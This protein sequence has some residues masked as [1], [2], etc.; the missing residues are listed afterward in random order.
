MHR[1]CL[2]RHDHALRP[3]AEESCRPMAC[4]LLGTYI[5]RR[6]HF[7]LTISTYFSIIMAPPE[8]PQASQIRKEV[9][10]YYFSALG[11][12]SFHD[13]DDTGSLQENL[14]NIQRH[15]AR[16]FVLDFSDV[17]AWI[18]CDL[19][20]TAI[21]A[22]LEAERPESLSTRWIN[23]WSPQRQASL[24]EVIAKKYDFS[25]RL[26]ALM[27]S[28]P[29]RRNSGR[30]GRS[31]SSRSYSNKFLR[32]PRASPAPQTVSED[33]IEKG[34]DDL[35]ELSAV[36][37]L[38]S[39]SRGNL[40]RIIDD[41]WHY[42][43]IDFGRSFVCMGYNSLYG[44]EDPT[45]ENAGG[46]LPRCVRLWTWLV[47][48]DDHT[49]ISI[50]EDPF[51]Y[52][53]GRLAESQ[54]RVLTETRRNL[55]NVFRSLS[56]AEQA[57]LLQHKPLALF[58]IRARLG[59][60][61]EESAHRLA[62]TPG[63]LFYFL[64]ENWHNSYTLITRRESHYGVE[65]KNLR[66]EMFD[67]PELRHVDRLDTIGTELGVLKHHFESYNRLIDRLLEPRPITNASIQNLRIDTLSSQA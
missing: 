26:L 17:A 57:S 27:T 62:D 55:V 61:E 32:K 67:K 29:R 51:P 42:H 60:T 54:N 5:L 63:L 19:S 3:T 46:R 48:C 34:S 12:Q 28:D 52:S 25:P 8:Q 64:F 11:S 6:Y 2:H 65:L 4:W 33:K 14:Q 41:L 7:F 66:A 53:G 31:D 21:D 1:L 38:E 35:S 10:A 30:S 49:V 47:L 36:S 23:I 18:S 15:D 59:D 45:E 39:V 9:D 44:V 20:S 37:S 43:S 16:N 56:K 58:P 24:I 50:N 22:L 40:F 13:L